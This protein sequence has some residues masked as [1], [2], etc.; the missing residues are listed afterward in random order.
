MATPVETSGLDAVA[1]DAESAVLSAALSVFGLS[2]S[3]SEPTRTARTTVPSGAV[4][5]SVRM[6]SLVESATVQPSGS[7][8][9]VSADGS[10]RSLPSHGLPSTANA[11]PLRSSAEYFGASADT[12]ASSLQ[13]TTSFRMNRIR[14]VFV[15][16]VLSVTDGS[17]VTPSMDGAPV[18]ARSEADSLSKAAR[19]IVALPSDTAA[20]AT[21]IAVSRNGVECSR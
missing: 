9:H 14:A 12:V 21:V 3:C 5:A 2:A 20:P 17:A 19:G 6:P 8:D 18:A 1:A 15:P 13:M 11:R 4:N 10:A 7:P 16:S